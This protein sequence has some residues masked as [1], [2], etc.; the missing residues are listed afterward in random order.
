M[1]SSIGITCHHMNPKV[2]TGKRP[3]GNDFTAC[4]LYL[5]VGMKHT[6]MVGH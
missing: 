6:K 3:T 5:R 2:D 1:S 4:S